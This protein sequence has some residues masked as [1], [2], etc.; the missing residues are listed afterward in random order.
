MS[1]PHASLI[2]ISL[3]THLLDNVG[4]VLGIADKPEVIYFPNNHLTYEESVVFLSTCK[5]KLK[6]CLLELTQKK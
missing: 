1:V 5:D 2:K 4:S 3:E 6:Q